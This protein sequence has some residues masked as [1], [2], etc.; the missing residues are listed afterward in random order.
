MVPGDQPLKRR[1]PVAALA[2]V[3][4]CLVASTAF[5]AFSV[6]LYRMFC[7]ATGL[8]GYTRRVTA[9]R[10]ARSD[11][12][13]TVAFTTDTAPDLPWVF[14]PEQRSVRVHLG[15]QA[16]AYFRAENR[17]H[18]R[19][20]GHATFNVTPYKVGAYFNKIQCFC[21]NEETLSPGAAADMPVVFY[22]DAK[23]AA[24]ADTRDVDTI[25]LAYTFFRSKSDAAPKDLARFKTSFDGLGSP[26]PTRGGQLFAER[27][28]AC[29]RLDG[30]KV[31]P[32]LGDAFGRTA[33]T[34]PG[35]RDYTDAL[36]KS[37]IV[38]TLRTLDKWLAGPSSLVPGT[39]MAVAVPV[40][41]D[42]RDLIAYLEGVSGRSAARAVAGR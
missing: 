20:V 28:A 42:R 4:V 30:T 19:I 22:V 10:S 6:P 34:V 27:C 1:R 17:G 9:D 41:S 32:Q 15:E 3:A 25:T 37:G 24:D 7:A 21:F 8:G 18:E 40:A 31:G 38:W 5:V 33:G 14:R 2:L 26:D 35:Y 23:L 16:I 13:V 11:R 39:R 36:A 29:H 12:L